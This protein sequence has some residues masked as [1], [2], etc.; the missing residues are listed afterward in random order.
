MHTEIDVPNPSYVL[1]PGMYATVQIPLHT[2]QNALTVPIQARAVARGC[3][4]TALIVDSE[5]KIEQR[6]V[7]LGLES[8]TD[9]KFFPG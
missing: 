3:N 6:D 5:N 1:V 2:V 4:G 7:T 8:A 9:A